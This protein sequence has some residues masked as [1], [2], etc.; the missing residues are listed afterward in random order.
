MKNFTLFKWY[1]GIF[2]FTSMF[3]SCVSNDNE[4]NDTNTS[5]DIKT[6]NASDITTNSATISGIINST[7]K[8]IL[9][10][11]ICINLTGNPTISDS[12]V[13]DSSGEIGNYKFKF[14]GLQTNTKYYARAYAITSLGKITYGNEINFTTTKSNLFTV[15]TL[16]PTQITQNSVLSG[17]SFSD[18]GNLKVTA[19]GICYSNIN[20]VPTIS[21]NKTNDKINSNNFTSSLLGLTSNTKYFIR[22]YLLINDEVYYGNVI[23]FTTLNVSLP[24][25]ITATPS[26]I[27]PTHVISGGAF[28]NNNDTTIISAGVCV[29]STN[30]TP[31]IT[32]S[33]TALQKD[34]N[35]ASGLFGIKLTNLLPNTKYFTRAYIENSLGTFY[36]DVVSFTTTKLGV[37]ILS[38]SSYVSLSSPDSNAYT[39][40]A[41]GRLISDGGSK[42]I[43]SGLCWSYKNPIP[44]VENIF[45]NNKT[46]AGAPMTDYIS[47]KMTDL[48]PNHVY[49]VRVY[50]TNDLGTGYGNIIEFTIPFK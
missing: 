18:I 8:E 40:N 42:I 4:D 17:G 44:T 50:A 37:P 19:V 15:K 39:A 25:V 13:E 20:E 47:G 22:S 6:L 21:D 27:N 29:S 9:H 14:D 31:S 11:G 43:E 46:I 24:T 26:S 49:Y 16:Q 3:F 28:L 2:L 32:E 1:A 33:Q 12:K 41:N 7:D 45:G 38:T 35:L 10:K 48:V 36:G 34:V 30:S 23:T 5:I